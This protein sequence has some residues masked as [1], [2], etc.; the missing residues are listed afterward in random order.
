MILG[1]LLNADVPVTEAIQAA[2]ESLRNRVLRAGVDEIYEDVRAGKTV[3]A[4]FRERPLFPPLLGSMMAAGEESNRLGEA[5]ERLARSYDR[6]MDQ[7]LGLITTLLEP[8]LIVLLGTMV[9]FIVAAML[10]PIF[11]ADFAA[12]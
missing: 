4:S 5:M 1:A 2:Q 12:P 10:L 9:A 11:Q 8:A 3:G 7:A 6:E